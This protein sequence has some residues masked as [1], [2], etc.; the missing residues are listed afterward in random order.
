MLARMS[1]TRH[2]E[3]G[4][5]GRDGRGCYEETASVEFKLIRERDDA[6]TVSVLGKV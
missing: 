5:V 3:I 4:R 1:L 6:Y 2:A